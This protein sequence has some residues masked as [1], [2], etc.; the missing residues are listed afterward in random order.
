MPWKVN[1]VDK[2][3]KGLAE[4]EKKEWVKIANRVL[5]TEIEKGTD[6]L[7]AEVIAIRTANSS[8][9]EYTGKVVSLAEYNEAIRGMAFGEITDA[10]YQLVL[11]M[12]AFYD[13]WYGEII[14]T[15]TYLDRLVK[16]QAVLKNVQPSLNEDHDRGRAVGWAEDIKASD[17][18][19][20]VKWKFNKVGRQLIEDDI[21]RYY[22][23]EIDSRKDIET[24]EIVYPIFSGAALTN[25]PVMKTLPP[26]H[27]SEQ[28]DIVTHDNKTKDKIMDFKEIKDF[29]FSDAEK[30]ELSKMLGFAE[31]IKVV[32]A[33]KTELSEKLAAKDEVIKAKDAEIVKLSEYKKGVQAKEIE[34]VIEKALS[35]GRIKPVD[36]DKWSKRLAGDFNGFSEILAEIPANGAVDMSEHGSAE[37]KDVELSESKK[38]AEI[39][40]PDNVFQK[41]F[42]KKQEAK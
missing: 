10:E 12:G 30:D 24:G 41:L 13:D 14:I 4:E 22:S 6:E 39:L 37:N 29:R 1:D 21:Y 33:E 15:K 25:H 36:K 32:E 16:N 5:K 18:G 27:L 2:F 9:S 35:E 31:K 42:G 3:K 19:L 40:L 38:A 28:G 34:D 20:L 7:E 26:A 8:F 11:P 23:A 17:E